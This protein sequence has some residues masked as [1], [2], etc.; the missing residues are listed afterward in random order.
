MVQALQLQWHRIGRHITPIWGRKRAP[1][2]AESFPFPDSRFA[3]RAS[4]VCAQVAPLWL[5]HHCTRTFIWGSLLAMRKD[6]RYDA[7]LLYVASMLHD[8]GLTASYWGKDATASCF[9]VEGAHAAKSLAAEA[10]WDERRQEALAEAISLHLNVAVAVKQGIEAHLL[11]AGAAYDVLGTS[12]REI[13]ASARMLVVQRY[14]RLGFKDEMR[15]CLQRQ[16]SLRPQSRVALLEHRF[17]F[18]RRIARA[19]FGE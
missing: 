11:H 18:R 8:L 13:A 15:V 2:T 9:G 4:E 17:Q 10:Q 12:F 19:P 14:P 16:S 5:Q 3:F 1:M 6:L 7:E